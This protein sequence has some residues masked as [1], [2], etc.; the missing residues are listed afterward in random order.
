MRLISYLFIGLVFTISTH[1]FERFYYPH[2]Q[3]RK[4]SIRELNSLNSKK[5]DELFSYAFDSNADYET[6]SLIL[7]YGD[8]EVKARFANGYKRKQLHRVWSISKSIS[9]ILIGIAE[10]KGLLS[11][12]DL[13]ADYYP[14]IE[15]RYSQS[16]KIRHLLQMSS[17]LDWKEGYEANPLGSNVIQMLY[18]DGRQDMAEYTSNIPFA[19]APGTRWLYSS[20]ETNLM[21]G[22]LKKSMPDDQHSDFP[23]K[24]LFEPIGIQNATWER[25]SSGTFVGSSYLYLAPSDLARIGYL[26][27]RA[28]KW[29]HQQIVPESWIDF[30]LGLAPAL[31]NQDAPEPKELAS[32]GAQWWLNRP[33]PR[34]QLTKEIPKAPDSLFFGSGHHGQFLAVFPDQ[35][36]ILV[37]NGNDKKESINRAELFS[38]A[39]EVSRKDLK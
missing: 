34:K 39:Y 9:A 4:C 18:V 8:C 11:R 16:L 35:Q 13:V 28:G 38:L 1:A 15:P 23:W 6:N 3:W 36:L 30:N 33:N 20:G 27:M 32:Y 12:E 19:F 29:N 2:E 14:R 17:G 26:Y 25:D 37:R 5:L 7:Y 21:M 10:Q 31:M 22:C 24:E